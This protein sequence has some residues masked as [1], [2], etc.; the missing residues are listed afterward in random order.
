MYGPCLQL[1][2]KHL[3]TPF[4]GNHVSF[5]ACFLLVSDVEERLVK[6]LLGQKEREMVIFISSFSSQKGFEHGDECQA[7]IAGSHVAF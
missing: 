7:V 6:L 5:C 2:N 3:W 4:V 1:D